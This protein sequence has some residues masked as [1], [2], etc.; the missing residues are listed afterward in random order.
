MLSAGYNSSVDN[1]SLP[2]AP[3]TFELVTWLR[4]LPVGPGRRVVMGHEWTLSVI[5][6]R[7]TASKSALSARGGSSGSTV[8]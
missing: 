8:R 2:R 5:M 7:I 4:V 3:G 1:A 6:G